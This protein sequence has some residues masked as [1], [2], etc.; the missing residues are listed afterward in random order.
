MNEEQ[1]S[2]GLVGILAPGVVH[3][4]RYGAFFPGMDALIPIPQCGP[5]LF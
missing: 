5:S 2:G 4:R 1:A 3:A